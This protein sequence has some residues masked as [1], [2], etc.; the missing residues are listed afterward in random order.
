MRR[1]LVG[2]VEAFAA[3]VGARCLWLETSNL[4]DPAIQFYRRLGFRWC[5]LDVSL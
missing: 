5:G 1:A 3:A 2:S 4:D